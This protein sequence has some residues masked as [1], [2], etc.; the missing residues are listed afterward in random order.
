MS[1]LSNSSIFKSSVIT[2]ALIYTIKS[3]CC[4]TQTY[5]YIQ[6]FSFWKTVFPLKTSRFFDK[7][8]W[9]I[10]TFV[11]MQGR[12]LAFCAVVSFTLI[13]KFENE[14]DT[15]ECPQ[16]SNIECSIVCHEHLQI[17]ES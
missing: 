5:N 8:N 7:E 4:S 12:G 2:E 11:V 6:L 10:A 15:S 13:R 17:T 14:W 9:L 3:S 1:T 16:L